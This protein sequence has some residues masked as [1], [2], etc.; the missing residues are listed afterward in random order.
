MTSILIRLHC[1]S[2]STGYMYKIKPALH[3]QCAKNRLIHRHL[4]SMKSVCRLIQ[5]GDSSKR[6]IDYIR[7]FYLLSLTSSSCSVL[8]SGRNLGGALLVHW[9]RSSCVWSLTGASSATTRPPTT[10]ASAAAATRRWRA[11]AWPGESTENG[12]ITVTMGASVASRPRW[13]CTRAF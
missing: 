10:S 6:Q 4:T 12:V 1:K 9:A 11:R 8:V 3:A 13:S 7:I 5:V 2:N